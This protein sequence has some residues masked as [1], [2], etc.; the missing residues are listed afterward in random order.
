[1]FVRRSILGYG[2]GSIASV[3]LLGFAAR[4]RAETIQ[5]TA[6]LTRS[7][8]VPPS[9]TTGRGTV[10]ATYDSVTKRLAWNGSYSGLSGPATAA[11]IHG[12]AAAGTNARL[13]FWISDN[14]GQCSQGECRSNS[15]NRARPFTSPFQGWA[16]LTDA[17]ATDLM[18]GMYYVNIHT[19]A[20]PRGE[21]RGQLVKS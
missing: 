15:D 20:Y 19:D 1:M 4:S 5:F 16:T 11:H 14:I 21:I 6:D 8:Q 13:V 17:Q 9:Q 10:T 2:I 3:V 12:P 7:N 18:A